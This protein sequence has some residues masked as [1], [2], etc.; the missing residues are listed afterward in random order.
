MKGSLL[1]LG[2]WRGVLGVVFTSGVVALQVGFII[3]DLLAKVLPFADTLLGRGLVMGTGW[4]LL[5]LWVLWE[6]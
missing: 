4:L 3:G 2:G 5:V 1:R 6:G